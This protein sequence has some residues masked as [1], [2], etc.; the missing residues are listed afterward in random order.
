M[1]D[2]SRAWR[3]RR[4]SAACSGVPGGGRGP[5]ARL[6]DR[7]AAAGD[8]QTAA[9]LYDQAYEA[10]PKSVDALVGLG[11]S[12]AGN[13]QFS[14]A[15]QALN[16]ANRRKPNDPGRAARAGP[17]PD[18]C[19]A[20]RPALQNLDV[21][22]SQAAERR[23]DPDR[24]SGIALDRLSRHAEAQD[25]YRKALQRDPTDFVVLSNLGL[26]L[27]LSG[28]TDEGIRIL[29]ELVRDGSA[30]RGPAATWRWCTGSR[31][32]SARR[33]RRWRAT[34]RRARSRTTSPTIA[35]S[36]RAEAKGKPIGNL[37][38]LQAKP[39]QV[40]SR[41]PAAAVPGASGGAATATGAAP[42]VAGAPQP[43]QLVTRPLDASAPSPL[44]P[45]PPATPFEPL[46]NALPLKV[47]APPAAAPA[48]TA[49][50]RPFIPAAGAKAAPQ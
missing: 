46:A 13:G 22:Q 6:A 25:V 31:G 17:D 27:G 38:Q 47:P 12:Y 2:W 28:R 1:G 44:A 30:T 11:R 39:Q 34:C 29:R 21:A 7:S 20:D 48:A 37:D 45:K 43:G 5:S 19:R 24:A 3:R 41:R 42:A 14:R 4:S 40:A 15:E 33:R 32:A 50:P 23:G 26:S 36:A 9:A 49:K 18:R 35:S 8:F 16:E 10:N